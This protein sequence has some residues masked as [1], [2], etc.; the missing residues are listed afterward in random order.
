M[1]LTAERVTEQDIA[2]AL[3]WRND[4]IEIYNNSWKPQEDIQTV[5]VSK[6]LEDGVTDGRGGLG[7]IFV[8]A[9]G[10]DA[11]ARSNVNHNPFANSRF[12]I[13]VGAVDDLGKQSWYSE[14]GAPVVI[15]APSSTSYK[16]SNGQEFLGVGITTTDLTGAEG[17]NTA[18][19][20]TSS[21]GGTSAAAA[22]VSGVVA[23]MLEANPDLS[24]RDVQQIL[25]QTAQKNDYTEGEEENDPD[26][27]ENWVRNG[28][29]Y[30]V[31]HKYGFGVVDA[32]RAVSVA[33]DWQTMAPLAPTITKKKSVGLD[34]P[35]Y[36]MEAFLGIPE[37]SDIL[38][39][40]D[41]DRLTGRQ[42]ETLLEKKAEVSGAEVSSTIE[43][44]EERTVEWV[45][46]TVD[47]DY[48]YRGDLK[49]ILESPDGTESVL[50]EWNPVPSPNN[51]AW[52]YTSI[53]H[54]GESS[55]G[56]W[57]LR[58]ADEWDNEEAGIWDSW[59]LNIY[60]T[61][62]S[63]VSLKA[64]DSSISEDGDATAFV[65]TREGGNHNAPLT[66][67][68]RINGSAANGL[69]Y[70]NLPGTIE[71][72]AGESSV[73]IPIIPIY[74]L[75]GEGA[76]ELTLTLEQDDS[77]QLDS[78]RI[79]TVTIQDST[80]EA[81]YGPFV[82]VNLD[83]GRIYRLTQEDTWLGAQAQ[84]EALGGNLVT[85]SSPEEQEWLLETF[86]DNQNFFIG[87]TKSNIY[88]NGSNWEWI[89]SQVDE[90]E[91]DY[92]AAWAPADTNDPTPETLADIVSQNLLSNT[93]I[94]AEDGNIGSKGYGIVEIDPNE[95][96][97]Q[98]QQSV[99]KKAIANIVA[100][101]G[102]ADET[103]NT[104]Q[105]VIS[106]VG[107]LDADLTVNYTVDGSATAEADYRELP[108]TIVIPAGEAQVRVSILPAADS[109]ADDGENVVLKLDSSDNYE[110]GTQSIAEVAIAD[111]SSSPT[112][113]PLEVFW[114][115]PTNVLTSSVGAFSENQGENNWYYGY[116]EGDIT[117]YDPSS[118]DLLTYDG[119]G[120]FVDDPNV[121][122]ETYLTA[123][124]GTPDAEVLVNNNSELTE[125]LAIRRWTSNVDEVDTKISISGK[126]PIQDANGNGVNDVNGY[127]LVD[128]QEIP[129]EETTVNGTT[130]EYKTTAEVDPDSIVEFV[131][132]SADSDRHNPSEFTATISQ[133]SNN[134]HGY[135]LTAEDTWLGAQAQAEALGGNLV[136]INNSIEQNWLT[137]T[138]PNT[139]NYW[140]GLTDSPL[141]GASEG[142]F[143]WVGGNSGYLNW[144]LN[145]P[146]NHL[147]TPEGQ[148]F[149]VLDN[150]GH[151]G[152][153]N[154]FPNDSSTAGFPTARG[155]VEIGA[156]TVA[157]NLNQILDYTEDQTLELAD[158][159]IADPSGQATVTLRLT[160]PGAGILTENADDSESANYNNDVWTSPSGSL[161]N[162][163]D[164]LAKVKFV[165]TPDFN[166]DTNIAVTVNGSQT[167]TG[168]IQLNANAGDDPLTVANNIVNL[169][170]ATQY[171]PLEITYQ[172]L[173]N[174]TGASDIDGDE[175]S[176]E[177]AQITS[178]ILTKDGLEHSASQPI[179][180][181]KGESLYWTPTQGGAQTFK[182]NATDGTTALPVEIAADVASSTS[183]LSDLNIVQVA[184][185][186]AEATEG[187]TPGQITF[188]RTGS[189]NAL[190]APLTVLYTVG[191][192]PDAATPGEDY[193]ALNG[194]VTFA[195]GSDKATINITAINDEEFT[196]EPEVKVTIKNMDAYQVGAGSESATVQ[197]KEDEQETYVVTNTDDSGEG[198]LRAAIEWV[199][200]QQG[201][202]SKKIIKFNIPVPEPSFTGVTGDPGDASQS[203]PEILTF[204]IQLQSALPE[205]NRPVIIDSQSQRDYI[206]ELADN[207]D[208]LLPDNLVIPDTPIIELDGSNAGAG[209]SGLRI[210][211]NAEGSTVRG[212][213][214]NGFGGHGILLRGGSG[215]TIAGNYIG[216]DV[217]GTEELGNSWSGIEIQ[218]SAENEISGNVLSGNSRHGLMIS[219]SDSKDNLAI[220]NKIGTDFS[221]TEELGNSENGIKIQG[222]AQNNTISGNVI[223]GNN[224]HGLIIS[225]N[226]S[227]GNEVIYNF[228]GTD[229]SGTQKLGNGKDGLHISYAPDNIIGGQTD[230][231]GNIVSNEKTRN[232]ISGN[233]LNGIT[234]SRSTAT[235]NQILGNYIGTNVEGTEALGNR[236]EG[237]E[238]DNAPQNII[239]GIAPG[240]RNV[241][242]GN[243]RNGVEILGQSAKENQ[244]LGNYIGTDHTGT[245]DLG[246]IFDGVK[247][248]NAPYNEIGGTTAEARNLISSNKGNGIEIE[249]AGANKNKVINNYIGTKINGTEELGN[250]FEG[251]KIVG[252][253]E[254]IIG[255]PSPALAPGS[256]DATEPELYRN[257]ISG[258]KRQG[259]AIAD[260]AKL[261]QVLGNYVGTD[262][263]GQVALGNRW[264]GIAIENA[265]ENQIGGTEAGTSNLISGNE[266]QGI[267][268]ADGATLNRVLANLIGTNLDGT[269]PLGNQEAGIEIDNAP[270]NAIGGIV[271]APNPNADP[272]AEAPESN[273]PGNLIA[274]N[275]EEGILIKNIG[276]NS[277]GNQVQGNKIGTDI[278]GEV[279]LG[280]G[281]QGIKIYRAANNTV[282]GSS[283]TAN[284][285][286]ANGR[287]GILLAQ[288]ETKGNE[289]QSNFIGTDL[290]G[291][292]NLGND[293]EGI[294]ATDEA[295]N[296]LIGG[297]DPGQGN[298]IA[299]NGYIF[300]ADGI[301]I[302]NG[303]GNSILGN[304][305]YANAGVG[306]DL[307]HNFASANDKGDQDEGPNGL[308]NFPELTFVKASGSGTTVRGSLNSTA[309]TPFRIEFFSNSQGAEAENFLGFQEVTTD[310]QGN[311]EFE[312]IIEGASPSGDFAVTATATEWPTDNVP[313]NNTSELSFGLPAIANEAPTLTAI[314]PIT[315]NVLNG[316]LAIAYDDLINASNADDPDGDPISF[317]ISAVA[318]GGTLTQDGNPVAPG[319]TLLSQ[320]AELLW[321]P[322]TGTLA[323]PVEAFQ[324]QAFDGSDSSEPVPVQIS[325]E[326]I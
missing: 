241:I 2:K 208:V 227:S 3:T 56:D 281:L 255:G 257:I 178:G 111:L 318:A 169:S 53:R 107:S 34:V 98:T 247:I 319:E 197:I 214:I 72:P 196:G 298:A 322:D 10:N 69:D 163:N 156:G 12:T 5:T 184:A 94:R 96:D 44:I 103:G 22:I 38:E 153:W 270:N 54:W 304:N 279:A 285:I 105:F 267:A 222:S 87:L 70:Q 252:G 90:E 26:P 292:L 143:Q 306:I 149:V 171:L 193:E 29:G 122:H 167:R 195:A 116:Y 174:S 221:G 220:N 210:G 291:I 269:A 161:E 165:P 311:V 132:D 189:P 148:D 126:M 201:S 288:P 123:D 59:S 261:N 45:E 315:G 274:A 83:S 192:T 265:R 74:D 35:D 42:N 157:L 36:D 194:Y 303:G 121:Q 120:W 283:Q 230:L 302:E 205:I 271:P 50:T 262:L 71:I 316:N 232:L 52:V 199:N 231:D 249:G 173:L 100:L 253:S 145:E 108:G 325:F 275:L 286:A 30:L 258:N 233:K 78:P 260:G 41:R 172:E 289:I 313:G 242:S 106:R 48:S 118:F 159:A 229:A 244:I 135:F 160:N 182:I 211:P 91:I 308:Q 278:S 130:V 97:P 142:D 129:L 146:N 305:I 81:S 119:T 77:Y 268:I 138:F 263:T 58:L 21:F 301:F 63:K 237:I 186:I 85:I 134:D 272:E 127:I 299:F 204:K 166:E 228:V 203:E 202:E 25:I 73:T 136:R 24:W 296:N 155:I 67:N 314:D 8:F 236:F 251:I 55:K 114:H 264:A 117:N 46:V 266:A 321:T 175:I 60:G 224:G 213:T 89:G 102:K 139:A 294:K 183:S 66:V 191:N 273:S 170:G 188:T 49:I 65:V 32:A 177:I 152:E 180:L 320:G 168:S 62:Q 290:A 259:I 11:W 287:E 284:V 312:A 179:A 128:G 47:S 223:S 39:N 209:V 254:N 245:A 310:A 158:I 154:D 51:N 115:K 219:G 82:Y 216:T 1:R 217:G 7:S 212:L 37:V 92:S 64:L 151:G 99:A 31:N 176:F 282:G 137:Q 293:W 250:F 239:G 147:H 79:D 150:S 198:S 144:G 181:T 238:I 18:S 218:N 13:A 15:S 256:D 215:S 235:G 57:T 164:L 225:G 185:S 246:N 207:P 323:N 110:I 16:N 88:T 76:E 125:H 75:D 104:G 141:Y 14:P 80:V 300:G 326:T 43:V 190:S 309:N 4:E 324:V 280:N 187:G 68:Y 33:R 95:V 109:V 234:I 295:S 28:A 206:N 124:G 200:K 101:D 112:P 20:Y 113:A 243:E 23:L 86:G 27:N 307:A 93:W 248:F 84:A 140:I 297:K 9:A 240:S 317:L 19:S 226:G 61:D 40:F 162:L 17:Y 277:V 6:A 276:I 131:L 133:E